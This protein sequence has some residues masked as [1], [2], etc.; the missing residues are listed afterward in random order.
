MANYNKAIQLNP[1]Y[2]DAYFMRGV[3]KMDLNSPQSAYTDF[4]TCITINPK[5]G[6][7]YMSRGAVRLMLGDIN[8]SMSDIEK[9]QHP[10]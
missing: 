3:L 1:K 5:S 7:C 8:G 4:T 10:A 6:H 2:D 9:R